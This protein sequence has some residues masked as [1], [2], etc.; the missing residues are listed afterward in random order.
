ML[1]TNVLLDLYSIPESARNLAL[2]ALEFLQDR[3][4]VPHQVL[5]EFWRNRQSAIAEAPVQTQPL[6]G[7]REELLAVVNSLRPDRE[8]TEELDEIRSQIDKTLADLKAQIDVARGTPLDV[9]RILGDNSLDPVLKRLESILEGRIGA[10]FGSDEETM[11]QKGLKRFETKVPPGYMDGKDKKDQI[12]E[13]GTGD[14]LLWEQALRFVEGQPEPRNFVLVT[15][16]NKED[17]RS[18]VTQPKKQVLGVRPEL[19]SEALERTGAQFMLL[20]PRDFYRLMNG[21]RSVDAD[22]SRSLSSALETVSENRT[23]DA[24]EWTSAAYHQLLADLRRDGYATQADVIALAAATGGLARRAEIYEIAGY[25][26]D[27]SL[28]R[29]SMPAQ[30][31]TIALI[32]SG[33]LQG[34]VP[35]P[36]E[37]VY[38]GPGKTVG[39]E[40]PDEFVR[41][42]AADQA[43]E[44]T[45][46]TW[47][48]AARQVAGDEPERVWTVD[49]LVASIAATELRD[50][51]SAQTPE[52]TLRRDLRLRGGELFEQIGSGF[53]IRMLS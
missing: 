47:I 22:S 34:E 5:R 49:E 40:V 36:L 19:V 52:A 4:F 3:L 48:E 25:A 23:R 17:W 10:S 50:I 46:H 1:D 24:G 11:V 6:D 16:D 53:R 27:R 14:Y 45:Q 20:D 42:A 28:R 35:F 12:P 37:A 30:R 15:N 2:D 38:E 7:V 8:R 51:S 29:F 26:D 39:Y 44:T 9:K 18:V 41:F 21:I 43:S 33:A 13:H 32:D 31:A